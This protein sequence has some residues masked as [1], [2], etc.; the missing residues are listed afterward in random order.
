MDESNLNRS[1]IS[2]NSS[3]RT[4]VMGILN[5]TPDSFA[6]GGRYLDFNAAL[7][8]ANLMIAEE[9]DIIDVGGESTRPGA[10]RITL[11]EEL[12]RTIPLITELSNLGVTISIDT[13]RAEVANAA[14]LAGASLVNDVSGGKADPK[15]AKVIARNPQVQYVVMHWRG[16]SEKMQELAIYE[17]VVRDVKAEL[18]DQVNYL[19]GEGIDLAQIIIDPGLG[20]SK[21]SFDNWEI[22]QKLDRLTLMGFPILI[23]ASRKKFLGELIGASDPD[24]REFA[25]IAL[26]T[27][28]AERGVWGVRVHNVKAHR[29]A[30]AV[31]NELRNHS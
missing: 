24:D 1:H 4:L 7:N 29:D 26:T 18:E 31:A 3:D 19:L 23:G 28:L 13:T 22:L 20:F 9:V 15:M 17:D 30:I 12:N 8:R 16:P 27:L 10:K 25:T 6:D 2:P 14:I 11:E 5:A 21:T